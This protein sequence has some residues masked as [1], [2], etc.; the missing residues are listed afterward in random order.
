VFLRLLL[1][2]ADGS[3]FVALLYDDP[4]PSL[5]GELGLSAVKELN[6]GEVEKRDESNLREK[7]KIRERKRNSSVWIFQ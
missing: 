3:F 1:P 6:P 2:S 5:L 7:R 4:P